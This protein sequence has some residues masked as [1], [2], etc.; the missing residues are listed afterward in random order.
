[1]AS[2]QVK[3]QSCYFP[4]VGR[5]AVGDKTRPLSV[6][7]EL[8]QPELLQE[9]FVQENGPALLVAGVRAAWALVL[10]TYTGLDQV[11]FGLSEVGGT[12][13]DSEASEKG[14]RESIATHIVSD[15]VSLGEVARHG[16]GEQPG[17]ERF[18]YN[19]SVLFRFAAQGST[20]AG[21]NKATAV[22]MKDSVSGP[23]VHRW[24]WW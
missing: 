17:H 7:V 1:M 10:R 23:V 14:Q 8:Q 24:C 6:R 2:D 3:A 16:E 20:K 11:C 12:V 22:S 9:L 13:D 21:L 18:D 4:A 5:A 15:E 19:T